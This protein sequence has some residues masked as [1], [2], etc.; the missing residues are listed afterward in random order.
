M[1]YVGIDLH[2]KTIS[3]CVAIRPAFAANPGR[4]ARLEPGLTTAGLSLFL[5]KSDSP[6][7]MIYNERRL[8]SANRSLPIE[9]RS[10][11][12]DCRASR[13]SSDPDGIADGGLV[14]DRRPHEWR[15]WLNS[16]SWRRPSGRSRID[17]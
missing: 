3:G 5:K 8:Q 16:L 10:L 4:P 13:P 7:G 14:S 17:A 12:G 11:A 2:K 15:R 1:K 6:Q 9:T